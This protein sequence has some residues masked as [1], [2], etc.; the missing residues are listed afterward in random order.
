M[1]MYHS[2][3]ACVCARLRDQD[4]QGLTNIYIYIYIHT[5]IY[6]YMHC[7]YIYI[8]ICIRT[9]KVWNDTVANLTLM[10]YRLQLHNVLH[11]VL[12]YNVRD[13]S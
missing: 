4:R 12:H 10:A 7:M 6:I 2:C 11:I 8:Y 13:L 9:V 5:H 3:F 1:Y